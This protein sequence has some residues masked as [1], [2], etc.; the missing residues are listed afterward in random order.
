MAKRSCR[1]ALR[2]TFFCMTKCVESQEIKSSKR[3]VYVFDCSFCNIMQNSRTSKSGNLSFITDNYFAF[4]RMDKIS[5]P[6]SLHPHL[7]KYLHSKYQKATLTLVWLCSLSFIIAGIDAYF[8]ICY[9]YLLNPVMDGEEKNKQRKR[10]IMIWTNII[11]RD[12][13]LIGHRLLIYGL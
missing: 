2:N 4:R 3:K 10:A 7:V 12:F 1:L 13:E 11:R 6:L 8:I 5:H 9:C